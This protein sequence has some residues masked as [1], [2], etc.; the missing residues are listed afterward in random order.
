MSRRSERI[1]ELLREELSELISRELRD[2]RIG[3][4]VSI[5]DIDTGDDLR[6]A[7]VYFSVLGTDEE[8]K[9][10]LAALT[11]ASGYLHRAITKRVNMRSVPYLVFVLDETIEKADRLTRLINQVRDEDRSMGAGTSPD[12]ATGTDPQPRKA[13][14]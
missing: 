7:K 1:N 6:Q 14:S 10:T 5:V 3:Q 9:E 8:K 11:S 2:P 12:E 13:I 4:I